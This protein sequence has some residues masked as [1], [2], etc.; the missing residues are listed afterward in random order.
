ME[1]YFGPV[2]E[3]KKKSQKPKQSRAIVHAERDLRTVLKQEVEVTRSRSVFIHIIVIMP[4]SISQSINTSKHTRLLQDISLCIHAKEE[5]SLLA[6]STCKP[7][8]V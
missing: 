2:Q 1:Q 7:N 3:K 6:K 5:R 4:S 8:N